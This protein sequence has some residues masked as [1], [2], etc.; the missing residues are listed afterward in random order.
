MDKVNQELLNA[1]KL[2]ATQMDAMLNGQGAMDMDELDEALLTANEAI[3]DATRETRVRKRV[4]CGWMDGP[5]SLKERSAQEGLARLE[6]QFPAS[7]HYHRSHGK[8]LSKCDS[9]RCQCG[10]FAESDGFT[11]CD[12]EGISVEPEV[13]KGWTG[14]V[15]CL[16]CNAVYD[17]T[18]VEYLKGKEG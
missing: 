14:L 13:G 4:K 16:R 18:G 11:P 1:L 10:N 15:V 12:Q 2:A 7:V 8:D 9:W 6:S 3:A 5:E 17:Q